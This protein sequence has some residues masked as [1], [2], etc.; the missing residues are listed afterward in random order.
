MTQPALDFAAPVS[1]YTT[2]RAEVQAEQQ[3][4]DSAMWRILARLQWGP[5]TG[6]ELNSICYRYTGRMSDLR[7]KHGYQIA[8]E[9]VTGGVWRYTLVSECAA[10]EGEHE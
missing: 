2:H 1:V 8:K 5:A 3:R 10:L 7:L 4:T 6:P 9:H